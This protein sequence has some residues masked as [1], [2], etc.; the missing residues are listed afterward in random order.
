MGLFREIHRRAG[1]VVGPTIAIAVL[2]YFLLHLFQGDRGILAWMQLRQQVASAE[3]Q[4]SG[5]SDKRRE[6]EAR[7]RLL[8][9]QSL[10]P[11]LLD[12]RVRLMTGLGRADEY[13]ILLSRELLDE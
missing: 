11:D 5:M 8:S 10:D 13:V 6:L 1:G 4:L 3:T 2:G 7:T 12:E 9:S